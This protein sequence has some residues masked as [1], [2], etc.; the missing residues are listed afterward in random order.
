VFASVRWFRPQTDITL[1][2]NMS[3]WSSDRNS[4]F[5]VAGPASI[6]PVQRISNKCV[7]VNHSLSPGSYLV[8]ISLYRRFSDNFQLRSSIDKW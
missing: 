7:M 2:N 4:Q 5:E 6:L 8:A 3:A 1:P